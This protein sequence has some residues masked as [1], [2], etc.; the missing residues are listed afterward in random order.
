MNLV[1][2]CRSAAAIVVE[3]GEFLMTEL[4]KV[5]TGDIETK[6]KNSLVSYVDKTAELRLAEGLRPLLPE[7][8]FL[9]EEA[10]VGQMEAGARWI[11]D[12]LDGTTNF[13]HG[14]PCFAISV[15]LELDGELQ[16]GIVYDPNRHELF[17][18]WKDGGA[19][20]N[21][22]PISVSAAPALA[23]ALLATGFPY[24]NFS[25][26]DPYL[27][28]LREL[29]GAT[30]GIR[31][32]G[33]AAIDLAYVACGRFDGFFEYSLQPWDIAAGVLLI[34]EAGGRVSDFQGQA[35][36]LHTG[37]VI[38]ANPAIYTALSKCIQKRKLA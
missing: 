6:S 34:R 1:T 26:I 38:A 20:L 17:T 27:D 4:G 25:Q 33:A 22:H 16:I 14:L 30:R 31:R 18:A 2:I 15:A 24:Y 35:D 32:W 5:R 11:I 36:F 28:L 7:V 21:D 3:T 23:D 9:T 12:P 13:L 37:S 10:T 29:M 8:G 19:Y